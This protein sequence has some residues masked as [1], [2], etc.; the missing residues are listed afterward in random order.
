MSKKVLTPARASAS[1]FSWVS[2]MWKMCMTLR[3]WPVT[4][5]PMGNSRP[6]ASDATSR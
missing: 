1:A 5:M 6:L 4:H 2:A 3:V